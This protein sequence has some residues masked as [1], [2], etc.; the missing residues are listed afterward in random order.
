MTSEKL[1]PAPVG[2]V[3]DT[4]FTFVQLTAAALLMRAF[5]VKHHLMTF[6]L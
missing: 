4:L 6:D 5:I 3:E 2:A 1:D